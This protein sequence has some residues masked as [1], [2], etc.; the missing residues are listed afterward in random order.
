MRS[1]A[2]KA[3][4]GLGLGAGAMLISVLLGWGQPAMADVVCSG[5]IGAMPI[6][7]NIA[8]PGGATCVLDGTVVDGNVLVAP[9]AT[10]RATDVDVSG[11]I[12][13]DDGGASEV[14]VLSSVVDGDIQVFDSSRANV[15]G[16]TVGGNIQLEGNDDDLVVTANQ[17]DGDV[18]LFG[19]DGGTKRI[20]GNTIGGNLQCTG[21]DPVPTGG[22]N[23]VQ[24]NA[25]GQCSNLEDGSGGPGQV[26]FV[27]V[28][29]SNPF[30]DSIE[31]LA[32]SGITQGCNPPVNDR[33]CPDDFVS[34]QQMAA[35]LV[36]ALNLPT[37]SMS[38]V[39][40]P[41]SNVFAGAI[42]SLADAGITLGCNPPVND[43]F[44]PDDFASRQQMAA[45]LVRAGLTN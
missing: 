28:P 25:E 1:P 6:D 4:E 24:G 37:G 42:S 10:L 35:F 13:T 16:T 12:Q 34:R 20:T 7:D 3:I 38:F 43:R 39:D 31:A 45:F 44:C 15:G 14:T 5:T 27:D 9:N 23:V 2:R 11:N 30:Y 8:V 36:R 18:Q 19:N 40:V 22:D 33:F 21:N 41:A 32:T 26:R 29:R 17:V